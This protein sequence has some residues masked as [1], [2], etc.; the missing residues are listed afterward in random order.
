M[1]AW[2]VDLK[3]ITKKLFRFFT[4]KNF[5]RTKEGTVGDILENKN[6]YGK[7]LE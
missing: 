1:K 2:I 6:K 4:D 5:T 7:I 3:T